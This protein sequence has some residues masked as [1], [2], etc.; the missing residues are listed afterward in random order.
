MRH[1]APTVGQNHATRSAG[2]SHWQEALTARKQRMRSTYVCGYKSMLSI[3][4]VHAAWEH[5]CSSIDQLNVRPAASQLS[6]KCKR[7]SEITPFKD[8]LNE[9]SPC[10]VR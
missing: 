3:A 10:L 6:R 5:S 7:R 9:S 8:A 1:S 4:S 2:E